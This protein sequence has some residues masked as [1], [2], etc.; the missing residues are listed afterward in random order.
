MRNEPVADDLEIA[1]RA[2]VIIRIAA[3]DPHQPAAISDL[4]SGQSR[5]VADNDP[6]CVIGGKHCRQLLLDRWARRRPGSGNRNVGDP[7]IARDQAA[8]PQGAERA[9]DDR[10][11]RAVDRGQRRRHLAVELSQRQL[12]IFGAEPAVDEQVAVDQGHRRVADH[13]AADL[14]VRGPGE[15]LLD[16]AQRG[17]LDPGVA[18]RG[19]AHRRVLGAVFRLDVF[20]FRFVEP[21]AKRDRP[22]PGEGGELGL[23]GVAQVAGDV[24]R[25]MVAD[26]HDDPPALSRRFLLKPHE[27]ADDLERIRAAVDDVADL[28]QRGPAAGPLAT[29]SDHA[30]RSGNVAPRGEVAVQV[31]DGDDAGGL[32]WRHRNRRRRCNCRSDQQANAPPQPPKHPTALP[33]AIDF[34]EGA[35]LTSFCQPSRIHHRS[36]LKRCMAATANERI[37]RFRQVG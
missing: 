16:P 19:G 21:I 7:G 18:D 15:P 29:R 30:R 9:S 26:Q 36:P 31:A 2:A 22:G 20:L 33:A 3:I 25:F 4:D 8:V 32:G 6:P 13:P 23:G 1:G 17:R 27:V 11:R 35:R 12:R 28:D 14:P 34:E 24:H 5:R 37:A 10:V